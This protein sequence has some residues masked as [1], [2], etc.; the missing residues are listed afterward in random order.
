[1]LEQHGVDRQ[2]AEAH[3][4]ALEEASRDDLATKADLREQRLAGQSDLG[5][6]KAEIYRAMMVQAGVIVGATVALLKL[7]P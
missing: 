5:E 6:F 2:T 1:V 3:A 7:I 4:E